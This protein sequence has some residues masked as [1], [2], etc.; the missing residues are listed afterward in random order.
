VVFVGCSQLLSAIS[1]FFHYTKSQLTPDIQ[2]LFV[3]QN[4]TQTQKNIKATYDEFPILAQVCNV[5]DNNATRLLPTATL[6]TPIKFIHVHLHV[7]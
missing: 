1:L 7:A 4:R 2:Q 5:G 3:V 6:V